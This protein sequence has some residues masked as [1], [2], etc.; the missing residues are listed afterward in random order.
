[1]R[2]RLGSILPMRSWG[3]RGGF[4]SRRTK[5]DNDNKFIFVENSIATETSILYSWW[6]TLLSAIKPTRARARDPAKKPVTGRKKAS[7]SPTLDPSRLSDPLGN[8]LRPEH[9]RPDG[10]HSQAAH[11]ATVQILNAHAAART[12]NRPISP[13][14]AVPHPILNH[15]TV[16]H[17]PA[18]NLSHPIA[19]LKP[20]SP[21]PLPSP[22]RLA[23]LPGCRQPT[24]ARPSGQATRREALRRR[25]RRAGMHHLPAAGDEVVPR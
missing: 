5:Q 6:F 12:S 10:V 13:F 23:R 22:P 7:A 20:P 4:F 24:L 9:F 1:M 8:F 19:P 17:P 15:H 21:P 3:V 18:T 2:S 16:V 14:L 11:N 25:V